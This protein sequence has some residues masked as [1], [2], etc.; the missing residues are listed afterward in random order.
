MIRHAPKNAVNPRA[1]QLCAGL[2]LLGLLAP[3][4]VLAEK[5]D[6]EKP[7]NLESDRVTVDDAK[8]IATFEGRVVLTQGTLIIRGD[9]MEVR[10]DNQG[11]QYGTTWGNLAYFRQ[12]REGYDEYIEGWAER[13]EYDGR[14]DKVQMFNR[15]S[16]KK[17]ADEVHGNYI[18]YDAN[19]EFFQVIGGG[20]RTA[21][22]NDGRVRAVL[23]PKPK[24]KPAAQPPVT[25]QQSDTVTAP[26]KPLPAPQR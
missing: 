13:I 5:A 12:K 21:G 11:F 24:T 3:G 1:L 2:L 7:I 10:Q 23:Q 9:R 26:R 15:A 8:Q 17:G 22:G 16:M 18:S 14:A 20:T 19:T 25:L 6:R 4:G